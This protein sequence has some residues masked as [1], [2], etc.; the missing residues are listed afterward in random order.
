MTASGK[1][2]G[3]V[4]AGLGLA[5]NLAPP[6]QAANVEPAATTTGDACAA[7]TLTLAAVAP[8]TLALKVDAPCH[9][10]EQLLINHAGLRFSARL[11]AQGRFQT[12]LPA[13]SAAGEV[14]VTLALGG[15][16]I[17]VQPVPDMDKVRRFAL[18]SKPESG[19]H[20]TARIGKPGTTL[21][22]AANPGAPDLS[23]GGYLSFLGDRSL[24]G[25]M[26]AEVATLPAQTGDGAPV[27]VAD[28][29]N[30]TCGH[31]LLAVTLT[32]TAKDAPAGGAVSFSMP[33]CDLVGTRLV[34]DMADAATP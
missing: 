7:P 6:A 26:L 31:D 19:L 17:A 13:M 16:L 3:L 10:D 22:D 25:A 34:L 5:L 20:L 1:L 4:L 18:L 2:A 9:P 11:D 21:L 14:T 32:S 27:I 15:D 33:D 29:T 30:T 28:V 24:T 12:S 23:K 8:A